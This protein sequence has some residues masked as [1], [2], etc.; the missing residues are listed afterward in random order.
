M[1]RGA[2][3]TFVWEGGVLQVLRG[4]VHIC[5]MME[6]A[7]S[8]PGIPLQHLCPRACVDFLSREGVTQTKVLAE[9]KQ[10]APILYNTVTATP[11]AGKGDTTRSK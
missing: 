11:L 4:F 2:L 6:A 5:E 10:G 3:S 1:C 7:C 9:G 8:T